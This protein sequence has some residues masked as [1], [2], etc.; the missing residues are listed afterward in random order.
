MRALDMWLI[1]LFSKIFKKKKITVELLSFDLSLR[2][3]IYNTET[4]NELHPMLTKTVELPYVGKVN[5]FRTYELRR[6]NAYIWLHKYRQDKNNKKTSLL[7]CLEKT[8]I[9]DMSFTVSVRVDA[10]N[11]HDTIYNISNI[12]LLDMEYRPINS[13]D[14]NFRFLNGLIKNITFENFVV[15]ITA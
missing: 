15:K 2:N 4:R 12:S 7:S 8:Y 14:E 1:S 9:L 3:I 5:G 6:K 13:S 10:N 11:R